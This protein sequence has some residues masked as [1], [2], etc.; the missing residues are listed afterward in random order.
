MR[1]PPEISFHGLNRSE[2]LENLIYNDIAK[3]EKLSD[4][5]ISCRV[6]IV[7]EQ[8]SRKTSNPY[9]VR[10]EMRFPPGHDLVVNHKSGLKEDTEDL[11]TVI[12]NG[13]KSAQRRLKQQIEKQQGVRKVHPQQET[14]ALITKI[15]SEEGYGF[16]R[17]TDGEEVYF[18]R[19]SVLNYD[20]DKL[21][22]GDGVNF[23]AELGDEGL[24]ASSVMVVDASGGR[25][26]SSSD[27]QSDEPLGWERE[28][29]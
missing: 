7:L 13:F 20:F 21:K 9:R 14:I 23:T 6:G 12:K 29:Y 28:E 4:N 19:N 2:Y 3:L 15:F 27:L 1:I 8:K 18:H 10:I 17:S 25:S 11:P 24:Q 16:L 22:P 26:E 5:L